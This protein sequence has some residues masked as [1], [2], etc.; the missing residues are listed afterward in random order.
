MEGSNRYMRIFLMV[1]SGKIFRGSGFEPKMTHGHNSGA[2]LR[3]F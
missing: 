1:F 2:A 3:I